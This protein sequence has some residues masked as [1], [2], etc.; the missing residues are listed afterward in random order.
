MSVLHKN[1]LK[2]VLH[3]ITR[4]SFAAKETKQFPPHRIKLKQKK[5]WLV[6]CDTSKKSIDYEPYELQQNRREQVA[7]LEEWL[8]FWELAISLHVLWCTLQYLVYGV[9][10]SGIRHIVFHAPNAL[11]TNKNFKSKG[12]CMNLSAYLS[13]R[14][15]CCR[16]KVWVQY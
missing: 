5:C 9:V 14:Y 15:K 7:T 8:S 4:R 10:F 1:M 2:Q 16:N 13:R 3:H 11:C 6:T 12:S